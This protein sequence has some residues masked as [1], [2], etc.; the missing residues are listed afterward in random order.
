MMNTYAQQPKRLALFA[1]LASLVALLS[2][3]VFP[4]ISITV[5]TSSTNGYN[6][7]TSQSVQVGAGVV[8]LFTGFICIE[9]LLAV[10]IG[11]IAGLLALREAPFGQ[12]SMPVEVQRRRSAY[13]ILILG[14]IAIIYQFLLVSI[15]TSQI[16]TA[17][18]NAASGTGT[19]SLASLFFR[20]EAIS[21]TLGYAVGSWLYLLAMLAVV[22]FGW[23]L[24][25]AERP[26][27]AFVPA[28]ASQALSASGQQPMQP[29]QQL[30]QQPSRVYVPPS[31]QQGQSSPQYYPSSQPSVEQPSNSSYV[32]PYAQSWQQ[33]LPP[34]NTGDW[35]SPTN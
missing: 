21:V 4:F 12:G 25:R 6:T 19:L 3:L 32:P 13:T 2:Y 18:Q 23:M 26:Q 35:H 10:A 15:G 22:G 7:S 24:L 1:A 16:N 33:P 31:L 9:A 17:I 5:T 28:Q 27:A 29:S 14:G 34:S 8:Q 11:C 30:W 20:S